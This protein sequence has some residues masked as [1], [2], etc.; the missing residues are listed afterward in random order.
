M[1]GATN[2]ILNDATGFSLYGQNAGKLDVTGHNALNEWFGEAPI[3]GA[4]DDKYISELK[5]NITNPK[6]YFQTLKN[7]RDSK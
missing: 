3:G 4:E 7:F 6:Q 5:N 1:A 2:K